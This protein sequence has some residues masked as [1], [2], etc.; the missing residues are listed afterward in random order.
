MPHSDVHPA[1]PDARDLADLVT[2]L[3]A[4][5]DP[6][7]RLGAMSY[8]QERA[9][10]GE[11]VT[12]LLYVDSDPTDLHGYLNTVPA[13]LNTLNEGDLCPGPA[14]LDRINASLR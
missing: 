2:R 3:A 7:D 4:D 10:E 14:A 12:G 5:Y 6:H 8:L 1:R 11:I 13:P 9:A